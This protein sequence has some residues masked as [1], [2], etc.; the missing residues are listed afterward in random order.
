[1]ERCHTTVESPDVLLWTMVG[2][3][4]VDD[5]RRLFAAQA[6]FC[7]GKPG[8]YVIVDLR[9]MQ[10]ISAEAR[11]ETARAPFIDG[12]PMLVHAIAIVGG[13][14]HLRLLGKMINRAAA[15]LHHVQETSIEFFDT[16]DQAQRWITKHKGM[17]VAET[18]T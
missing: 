9:R 12:K 7:K 18:I 6:E 13:S 16:L 17:K 10:Q 15:V 2:D 1:M 3:V 8:I 11:R 14:F 5:V 4:S